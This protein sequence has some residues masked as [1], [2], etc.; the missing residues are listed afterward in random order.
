M[1][2]CPYDIV[3]VMGREGRRLEVEVSPGEYVICSIRKYNRKD[4][5]YKLIYPDTVRYQRLQDLTYKFVDNAPTTW[6]CGWLRH[7]S[8]EGGNGAAADARARRA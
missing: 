8:L 7:Q 4:E 2:R 5:T 3:R 1:R 6:K